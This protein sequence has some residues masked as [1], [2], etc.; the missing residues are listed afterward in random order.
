MEQDTSKKASMKE[1][2]MTSSNLLFY[3]FIY[4]GPSDS[5]CTQTTKLNINNPHIIVYAYI[6]PIEHLELTRWSI[7][8]QKK[9]IRVLTIH[10]FPLKKTIHE[11]EA[12][13]LQTMNF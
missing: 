12:L 13:R 3:L 8:E 2:W 4:F 10:E 6:K 11:L 5:R 9:F 7:K 1:K